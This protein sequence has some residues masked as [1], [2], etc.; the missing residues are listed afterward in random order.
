MYRNPL[1]NGNLSDYTN[2]LK[3]QID[4]GTR[5]KRYE[6][7]KLEV[8][9]NELQKYYE[10]ETYERPILDELNYVAERMKNENIKKQKEDFEFIEKLKE[11]RQ[12]LIPKQVKNDIRVDL[13]D[14]PEKSIVDLTPTIITD[15]ELEMEIEASNRIKASIKRAEIQPLY[16]LGVKTFKEEEAKKN[17]QERKTLPRKMEI[18][19]RIKDLDPRASVSGNRTELMRRLETLQKK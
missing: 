1:N 10:Y 15:N 19:K 8:I 4:Y 9:P 17:R 7:I 18:Q 13:F 14:Y 6:K 3:N 5:V 2:S 11:Q 16:R 12:S